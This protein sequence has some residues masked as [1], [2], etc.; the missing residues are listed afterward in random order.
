LPM[1]LYLIFL[2]MGI[3]LVTHQITKQK[4]KNYWW[5]RGYTIPRNVGFFWVN[6]WIN[7]DFLTTKSGFL[8]MGAHW[9]LQLLW[10]GRVP[11][12]V[13]SHRNERNQSRE[14]KTYW[15]CWAPCDRIVLKLVMNMKNQQLGLSK[16]R[17]LKLIKF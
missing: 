12:G 1:P 10:L 14:K 11:L 4:P 13:P 15:W 6:L 8:G 17:I 16:G 9:F 3:G 7:L 5:Q 2:F